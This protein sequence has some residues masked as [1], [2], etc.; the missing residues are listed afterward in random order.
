MNLDNYNR[1]ILGILLVVGLLVLVAFVSVSEDI[2]TDIDNLDVQVND[3]VKRTIGD[4]EII[5]VENGDKIT[6]IK[7]NNT[8]VTSD[9]AL[10]S[11]KDNPKV[12]IGEDMT[13]SIDDSLCNIEYTN[14]V[15]SGRS[16]PQEKD[17]VSSNYTVSYGFQDRVVKFK[18]SP[19]LAPY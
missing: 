10:D 3:D 5:Y 2:R 13:V 6:F 14:S 18:C 8:D 11:V 9:V 15:L 17:L 12:G 1:V 4:D 16:I 19:L 7:D